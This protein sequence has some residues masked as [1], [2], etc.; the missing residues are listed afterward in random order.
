MSSKLGILPGS[1]CR[2]PFYFN[3]SC[4]YL[5]KKIDGDA[6]WNECNLYNKYLP[7]DHENGVIR[8]CNQCIKNKPVKGGKMGIA[9]FQEELDKLLTKFV[10]SEKDMFTAV[11]AMDAVK[12]VILD[13][14]ARSVDR[15][16]FPMGVS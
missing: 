13:Q 12:T 16:I 4:C 3:D 10:Q 5:M 14:Y 11:G 9:E 2:N 6:S 15:E 1:Y 8:K 7:W